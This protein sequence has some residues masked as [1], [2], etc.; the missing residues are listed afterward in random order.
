MINLS[1][2]TTSQPLIIL[3]GEYGIIKGEHAL[4]ASPNPKNGVLLVLSDVEN[5]ITAMA[6]FDGEK[7]LEKN[8][9]KIFDEMSKSGANISNLKCNLIENDR[10]PAI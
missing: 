5:K 9:E 10:T 3:R 4:A 1:D 7:N 2:L 8:L 6:H